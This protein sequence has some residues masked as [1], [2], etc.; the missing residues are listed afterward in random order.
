MLKKYGEKIAVGV[1]ARDG[2]VAI[3]GWKD[4]SA[5]PGV[6]FCQR[7]AEAG[8][9]AIIYTD[10][11]CDGAMKGTNLALYRQLAKKCRAWPSR[12][13]AVFPRKR[14][15]WNWKRWGLPPP[16]SARACTPVRWTLGAASRW[17]RSKEQD[18]DNKT[19]HPCLDVR[20]GRVVKERTSRASRMWPTR[21]K[22]PGCTTRRARTSWCSTTS[23]P[24]PRAAPSSPTSSP[25]WPARSS[26]HSRWAAASTRWTISTGCSSVVPIKS[27]STRAH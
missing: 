24:A 11:A 26:S 7:L 4:V 13:A 2:Y 21:W 5:E 17:C 8:C 23:R 27:A 14:S 25:G 16:S 18:H 10:I 22:W 15:C 12:P 9:K 6:A 3:H 1:D 20:N 19:H